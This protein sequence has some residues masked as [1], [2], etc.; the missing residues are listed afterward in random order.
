MTD[1]PMDEPSVETT[2]AFEHL[3]GAVDKAMQHLDEDRQ[4]LARKMRWWRR[5]VVVLGIAVVVSVFTG[6]VG[7]VI[8]TRGNHAL[9]EMR[10][11]RDQSRVTSCQNYNDDLVANVNALNDKTQGVLRSALA[12]NPNATAQGREFVANQ[13]AEFEKVKVPRRDCSPK[14]IAAYYHDHLISTR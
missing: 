14:G 12:A 6:I 3:A 13:V 5:A 1:E 10:D 2:M 11:Q 8:G 7:I 4:A 9:D